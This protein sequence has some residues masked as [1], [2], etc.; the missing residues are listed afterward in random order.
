MKI[1]VDIDGVLYPFMEDI[2]A[3]LRRHGIDADLNAWQG[4]SGYSA[5][6]LDKASWRAW[7]DRAADEGVLFNSMAPY[8][9]A[10]EAMRE[11][12]AAGHFLH[13]VTARDFGTDYSWV[14]NT[15]AWLSRFEIPF[16]SLT[17]DPDKT[18]VEVDVFV[19][20]N[21][22]NHDALVDVG[23][24]VYLIDTRYNQAEGCSRTRVPDFA[25]AARLI[26]AQGGTVSP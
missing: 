2:S 12:T 11:L 1:G 20:D 4:W 9:G 5:W 19:E 7:C 21:L 14:R 24:R 25:S 6:G 16:H 13:L 10:A 18:V 23:R 8:P 15:C 17:F 3:Y 26:L 22:S